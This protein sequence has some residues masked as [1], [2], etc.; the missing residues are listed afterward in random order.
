MDVMLIEDDD[1]ESRLFTYDWFENPSKKHEDENRFIVVSIF[2]NTL[3][4]PISDALANLFNLFDET[5]FDN[6]LTLLR[7]GKLIWNDSVVLNKLTKPVI[8][9]LKYTVCLIIVNDC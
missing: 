5:H 3:L 2:S 7:M 1:D 4:T 8:S 9:K 6:Y